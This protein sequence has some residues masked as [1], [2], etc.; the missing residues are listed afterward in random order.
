MGRLVNHS[1]HVKQKGGRAGFLMPVVFCAATIFTLDYPMKNEPPQFLMCAPDFYDV[2][3]VINPWMEGNVGKTVRAQAR[4]QW[5]VLRSQ[6]QEIATVELITPQPG[7][8]DMV[9][10]ANAA[11]IVGDK[12]VLSHFLYRERR[13]EEPHFRQWFNSHGFEVFEMPADLPFEGAGDALLDH[14]RGWLW[15]GYGLRTELDAHPLLAQWLNAEVVSL[16]LIDQRYYHL[17]TCLCPLEDGWLLYYPPAFDAYSNHVIEQRV[18]ANRRIAVKE[19][20]A[21]H[22]VCNA[23]NANRHLFV[24]NISV[25]LRATLEEAG[26]RVRETPLGEFL[27]AGGTAKCLTLRLDEPAPPSA[28]ALSTVQSRHVR[29]EGHLLDSGLLDRATNVIVDSG[30]SF[31]IL[32]FQLGKQR[33][34]TSESEIQV[35]AP[36]EDS[37]D[38]IMSRLI[39]L[40]ASA[41]TREESDAELHAVTQPGVA[42]EDFYATTIYPAEVRVDGHWL[43]VQY[44][45]M[46]A[47]IVVSNE[48]N[49]PVAR[50]KLFRNLKPGE[51]VVVGS[52]GIRAVRKTGERDHR[53]NLPAGKDF[54]FMG[55]SVSSERRVEL[56]VERI[57]WE[58]HRIRE[59]GGRIVVAVGP[60]VVHTGGAPHLATLIREGYVQAVLGGNGVAVHDIEQSLLGTS[61]GVDVH[62]GALVRG[63]HRH[64]LRAINTI[65]R[66]GGIRQAV[67]QGVLTSGIF[68]E[69]VRRD[70]PFVLAA[71]I[72]DDGPLPDTMTDLIEAQEHYT[73]QIHG[74][75]MILML[76]S[77]LHSIGVGNMTPSGVRLVCVDINPAVVTKLSD[78][79]SVES[80]GVVTDVGSFLNLLVRQLQKLDA[81]PAALRAAES[82]AA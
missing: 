76:A 68:Y 65:R 13:H 52:A 5:T 24:N 41:P 49:G 14:T 27:K 36:S 60:V 75:D 28:R 50:C 69:C 63:G 53:T 37:L 2:H 56:V 67:E 48:E 46:D 31:R 32:D 73:C 21:M 40:G 51:S 70:V 11:V 62:A 45:R 8:P 79:G 7:L 30:G 19:P 10:T 80:V 16:R 64:H 26:F 4:E 3:Y 33:Q 1:I 55:A 25:E 43:R 17:D 71:S 44:Q 72:R 54:A 74:A 22:F 66:C 81:E 34:S 12:A 58:M 23:V 77:M 29:L 39:D 35:S 20:D 57:A 15:A 82:V 42:P 18:P 59:R 9:F 61:L 78:R 38:K 47:V 6:L